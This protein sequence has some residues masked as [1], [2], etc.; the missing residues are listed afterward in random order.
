WC[1]CFTHE[2]IHSIFY[3]SIEVYT[4]KTQEK[5][6]KFQAYKF[7]QDSLLS[8]KQLHNI[9]FIVWDPHSSLRNFKVT[10]ILHKFFLLKLQ[11]ISFMIQVPYVIFKT[12]YKFDSRF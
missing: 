4:S 11:E 9:P 10:S 1:L 5:L 12:S 7:I 3:S 8:F 2:K 6:F